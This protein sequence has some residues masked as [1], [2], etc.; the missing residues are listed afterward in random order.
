MGLTGIRSAGCKRHDPRAGAVGF[1]TDGGVAALCQYSIDYFQVHFT[2]SF[3]MAERPMANAFDNVMPCD[4]FFVLNVPAS[5]YLPELSMRKEEIKNSCG[6][7]CR[8]RGAVD[9]PRQMT[10][11]ATVITA[12]FP[13]SVLYTRALMLLRLNPWKTGQTPMSVT[14]MGVCPVFSISQCLRLIAMQIAAMLYPFSRDN[15]KRL[16]YARQ[17]QSP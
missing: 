14:G 2:S 12:F 10:T 16:T 9:R 7:R 5:N 13:L 3:R 11:N 6:F 17:K 1:A 4:V 8:R 15:M